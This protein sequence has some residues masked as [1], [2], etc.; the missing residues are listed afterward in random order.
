M[1]RKLAALRS[2]MV[3]ALV[4]G[5]EGH[6]GSIAQAQTPTPHSPG[7]RPAGAGLGG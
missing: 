4:I 6:L 2:F 7:V 1:I 3:L 5:I